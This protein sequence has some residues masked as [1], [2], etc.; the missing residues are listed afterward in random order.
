MANLGLCRVVSKGMIAEM[1]VIDFSYNSIVMVPRVDLSITLV[2][3]QA[4]SRNIVRGL[5]RSVK[6]TFLPRHAEYGI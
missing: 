2:I 6:T 1:M 3:I 4:A 5:A